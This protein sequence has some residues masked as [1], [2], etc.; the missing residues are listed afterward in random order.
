MTMD[1][2]PIPTS[3]P[4]PTITKMLSHFAYLKDA[5]FKFPANVQAM[6]IL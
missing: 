2:L 6:V 1:D 5:G 3:H 4:A